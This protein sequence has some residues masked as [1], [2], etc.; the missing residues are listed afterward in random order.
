MTTGRKATG[1]EQVLAQLEADGFLDL[2]GI[3]VSRRMIEDI[4]ALEADASA[5]VFTGKAL[6]IQVAYNAKVSSALESLAE[7]MR[8]SGAHVETIGIREQAFWDRV[9]GV[10]AKELLDTTCEWVAS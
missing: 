2:D 7:K 5:A 8:A 10:E 4:S 3:A 9:E 6:C 1:R